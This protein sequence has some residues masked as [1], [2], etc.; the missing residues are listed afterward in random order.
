V[1]PRRL[2]SAAEAAPSDERRLQRLIS[3]VPLIEAETG[4]NVAISAGILTDD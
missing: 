3:L 4:L 1:D 2:P